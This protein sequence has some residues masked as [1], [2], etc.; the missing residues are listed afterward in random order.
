MPSQKPTR[1]SSRNPHQKQ[2]KGSSR[3]KSGRSRDRSGKINK[4]GNASPARIDPSTLPTIQ[5]IEKAI[6]HETPDWVGNCY[7]VAKAIIDAGLIDGRPRYG[8]FFGEVNPLSGLA[9]KHAPRHGWIELPDGAIVDPTRWVFE[10]VGAYLF[11]CEADDPGANNYDIGGVRFVE[12]LGRRRGPPPSDKECAE[13]GMDQT[14]KIEWSKDTHEFLTSCFGRHE[15]L[16]LGQ[17][18]WLTHIPPWEFDFAEPIYQAVIEQSSLSG[19]IPIDFR[20]YV[21]EDR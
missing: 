21:M 5:E 19:L 17:V 11:H 14:T 6:D 16:L 20:E 4:N 18:H 8:H 7:A 1:K 9:D 13:M 3:H 2:R 12:E 10:C 15:S